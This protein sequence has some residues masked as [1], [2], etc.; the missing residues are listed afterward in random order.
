MRLVEKRKGFRAA[1][2]PGR[3]MGSAEGADPQR[4]GGRGVGRGGGRGGR[5]GSAKGRDA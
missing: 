3:R 4:G 5:G 2:G 1:A